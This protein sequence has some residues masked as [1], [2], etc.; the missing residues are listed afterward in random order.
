MEPLSGAHRVIKHRALLCAEQGLELY[1]PDVDAILVARSFS[2]EV[3]TFC[4]RYGIITRKLP[5]ITY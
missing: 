2:S 3:E 1:D 4:R 5:V